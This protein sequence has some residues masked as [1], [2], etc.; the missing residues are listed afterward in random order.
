ME[1]AAAIL[2]APAWRIILTITFPL[3][4]PA[5]VAGALVAFLRSLTLYVHMAIKRRAPGL[6]PPSK[7]KGRLVNLFAEVPFDDPS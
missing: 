5:L 1:D 2:G 4:L 6:S 7:S 3:A